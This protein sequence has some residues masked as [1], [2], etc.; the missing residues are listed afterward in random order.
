MAKLVRVSKV[1]RV[2]LSDLSATD[3][4]VLRIA[5]NT[6]DPSGPV[7]LTYEELDSL[8][9]LRRLVAK[10]NNEDCYTA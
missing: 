7:K 5:L 3:W 10:A 9:E 8:Y 2:D 6:F 4:N 1:V